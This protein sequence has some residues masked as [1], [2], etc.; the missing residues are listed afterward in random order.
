VTQL[1]GSP[2]T[3]PRSPGI[4]WSFAWFF[5]VSTFILVAHGCHGD[6]IDHEP[7]IKVERHDK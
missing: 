6:D 2:V 3:K 1:E 5:L 4:R 7:I